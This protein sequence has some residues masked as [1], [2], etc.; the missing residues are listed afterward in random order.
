MKRSRKIDEI[1]G[2]TLSP[3]EMWP[4]LRVLYVLFLDLGTEAGQTEAQVKTLLAHTAKEHDKLEAAVAT[5]NRLLEEA[6]RGMPS[7]RSFRYEDLPE[8]LTDLP[9][10]F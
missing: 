10:V 1:E 3:A 6:S 9:Q 4:F 2:R 8:D 7:A 5:W